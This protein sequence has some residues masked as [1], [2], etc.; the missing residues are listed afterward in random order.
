[1]CCDDIQDMDLITALQNLMAFMIDLANEIKSVSVETVKNQLQQ[2]IS[3]QAGFIKALFSN[4]CWVKLSYQLKKMEQ[5]MGQYLAIGIVTSFSISKKQVNRSNL[6]LKKLSSILKNDLYYNPQ[7]YDV[8]DSD[9][10]YTFS[11]KNDIFET[12]LIGMLEAIYPR[13]YADK[14]YYT[15]VLD[16]LRNSEPSAWIEMANYKCAEAFQEDRYAMDEYFSKGNIRL[17]LNTKCILLSMEGK[18]IMEEYGDQFRFMKYTMAQAFKK[19]SL[20]S[21]LRIYIT[22]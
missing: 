15:T 3:R 11:L 9:D 7:I 18:I 2:W 17:C 22:G 16:K 21:A 5:Y 6:S 8:A 1:M 10:Y 13:I 4:L 14:S 20:A 12:Q 19:F